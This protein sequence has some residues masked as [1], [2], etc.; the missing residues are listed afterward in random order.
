MNGTELTISY[1]GESL[2]NHSMDVKELAPALLSMGKLLDETNRLVNGAETS[3]KVQVKAHEPGSFEIVLELT[4][5]LTSQ[6][7]K[8]FSSENIKTATEIRNLIFGGETVTAGICLYWLIRKLKGK[9]PEKIEDLKNGQIRIEIDNEKFEIPI[10]LMR[11]YQERNIRK[12]VEDT[13]AP[14]QDPGIE[15]F[16]VKQKKKTVQSI[17]KEELDI[18]KAPQAEDELLVESEHEAAY[19]IVSL[20]FKDDNKW[21]LHDGNSSI[22]VLIK[23]EV[24]LS[25]VDKSRI[26]F[27]KGDIL[28]CRVK[29]TQW[30]T[31]TGLKTE[32]EVIEVKE[33]RPSPKQLD[34]FDKGL[35]QNI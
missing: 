14:L 10:Y 15:K 35:Q 26:S 12:S 8:L 11:M 22:S 16:E 29:K 33:H 23:D 17:N 19:S 6:L 32:Y 31:E 5:S 30:Q 24:F 21:R 3:I 28:M 25:K 13:L 7:T 1:D 4:Q 2:K 27:S 34:I 18:F 9:Q 20:A